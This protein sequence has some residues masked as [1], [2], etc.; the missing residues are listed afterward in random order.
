MIDD[1]MRLIDQHAV[2]EASAQR[3]RDLCSPTSGRRAELDAD[4]AN[5]RAQIRVRLALADSALTFY[6]RGET[7]D[8]GHA[9]EHALTGVEPDWSV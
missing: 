9:A 4:A 8:D 5:L 7:E 1:I 3:T 2:A 6:A